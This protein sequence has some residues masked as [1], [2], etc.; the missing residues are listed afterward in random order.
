M[1]A[2]EGVWR[3]GPAEDEDENGILLL[4]GKYK[5]EKNPRMYATVLVLALE[6]RDD[7]KDATRKARDYVLE[8]SKLGNDK[9]ELVLASGMPEPNDGLG[10]V[11]QVGNRRGRIAELCL[12]QGTDKMRFILLAVINDKNHA[13]AI[14]C[15]C[16][17]EARHIWGQD[18]RDLLSQLVVEDN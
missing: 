1:R 7:L 5:K 8:K 9:Y 3:K 11:T 4:S 12:Q 17:W 6:K 15:D 18:F 13:Y 14:R 10:T 16:T 2:P